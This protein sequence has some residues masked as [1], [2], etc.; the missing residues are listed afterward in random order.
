[1][2]HPDDAAFAR[3]ASIDRSGDFPV[4]ACA[5]LGLTK[6]EY[7]AAMAL[8]GLSANPAV[9]IAVIGEMAVRRADALLAELAQGGQE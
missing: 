3:P 5:E 6:R 8:A 7:F 1:M 4:T 2:N 9:S